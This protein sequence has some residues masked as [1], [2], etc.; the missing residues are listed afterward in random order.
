MTKGVAI[1][2]TK[3]LRCLALA[4][5]IKLV[6]FACAL[7]RGFMQLLNA[8]SPM[9]N[10]HRFCQVN[11]QSVVKLRCKPD[12]VCEQVLRLKAHMPHG[13][14]VRKIAQTFNRSQAGKSKMTV[15]KTYVANTIRAN[16]YRIQ[17]L[18]TAAAGCLA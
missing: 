1:K 7:W 6:R 15:T 3:A 9:A 12:W 8:R 18:T 11:K 5:L 13:T 14:G 17:N 10:A 2:K 4:Q 16:Q